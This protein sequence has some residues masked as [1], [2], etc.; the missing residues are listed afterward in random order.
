[1]PLAVDRRTWKTRFVVVPLFPSKTTA[2]VI[3]TLGGWSSSRMVTTL[4]PTLIPAF[5][6]FAQI[7]EEGFISLVECVAVD[8]DVDRPGGL[9]GGESECA[10]VGE[11]IAGRAGRAIGSRPINGNRQGTGRGEADAEN[12]VGGAALPSSSAPLLM[13][14]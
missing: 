12:S 11:V 4:W 5:A 2:S 9:P 7:Y 6:A 1:L 10:G 13:V 8:D 3:N 14:S